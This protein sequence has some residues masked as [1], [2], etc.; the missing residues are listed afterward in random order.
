MDIGASAG[1][2]EGDHEV[3]EKADGEAGEEKYEQGFFHV[4]RSFHL[5]LPFKPVV[6][7][8]FA[9]GRHFNSRPWVS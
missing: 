7:T 5:F 4:S 2:D 3:A 8:C 9:S 6:L 1:D